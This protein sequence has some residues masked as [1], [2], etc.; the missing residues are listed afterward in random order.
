ML[1]NMYEA[2]YSYNEIRKAIN[3][4]YGT[5]YTKNAIIGQVFRQKKDGYITKKEK[6]CI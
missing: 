5:A 1:K 2:G 3:D 4:K 6:T